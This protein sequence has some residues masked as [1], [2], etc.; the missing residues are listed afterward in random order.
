MPIPS[1]SKG[2]Y[3]TLN[4][5]LREEEI[6]GRNKGLAILGAMAGLGAAAFISQRKTKGERLE[7]KALNKLQ[8][9][10][11]KNIKAE[12]L[13]EKAAKSSPKA[14][15]RKTKRAGKKMEKSRKLFS[16]SMKNISQAEAY[17]K[18]KMK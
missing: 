16:E 6:A 3:Q 7:S 5:K 18:S 8:R 11:N 13:M 4:P 15:A 1:K 17:K 12:K 10:A 9:S 14:A 2:Q